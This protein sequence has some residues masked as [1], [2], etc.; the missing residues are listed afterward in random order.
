MKNNYENVSLLK[1]IKLDCDYRTNFFLLLSFIFNIIYSIF[2]FVV[3]QIFFSKWF[4][5]MAI[6]YGLLSMVRVFIFLKN[7][8]FSGSFFAR[9][10]CIQI[11]IYRLVIL[12]VSLVVILFASE[13]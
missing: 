11:S 6:Y 5:V 13:Q 4:F 10:N 1:K 9:L 3:S 7:R 12:L 8:V 2:L